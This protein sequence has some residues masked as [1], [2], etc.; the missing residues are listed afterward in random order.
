MLFHSSGKR[1]RFVQSTN[2]LEVGFNR[3]LQSSKVRH[4]RLKVTEGQQSKTQK[5]HISGFQYPVG[6]TFQKSLA[7]FI[8]FNPILQC[9][10]VQFNFRGHN[11][12]RLL[13]FEFIANPQMYPPPF[14][15][16]IK[17]DLNHYHFFLVLQWRSWKLNSITCLLQWHF[18]WIGFLVL[19]FFWGQS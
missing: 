3:I 16:L 18:G 13:R 8:F 2:K 19:T 1:G 4:G 7:N 11:F 12:N 5:K 17:Q 14:W 9:N 15:V 10:L 6:S